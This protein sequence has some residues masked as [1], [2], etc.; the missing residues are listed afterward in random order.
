[1]NG[2][3]RVTWRT[4]NTMAQSLMVHAI[5]L[6]ACVHFLLMYMADHIFPALPI[7]DLIN[8]VGEPTTPYKLYTGMKYLILHK[9]VL[10]F[11]L[12]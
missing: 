7:K 8:K 3:V 6:E 4:L 11:C 2:Q 5:V 9:R 1:M 12:L 10:F